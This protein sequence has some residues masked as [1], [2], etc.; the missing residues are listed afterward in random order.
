MKTDLDFSI[1]PHSAWRQVIMAGLALTAKVIEQVETSG[2]YQAARNLR[3]Q[4][5]PLD[6][7]LALIA[8]RL[9]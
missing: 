7:A 5:Y 2:H 6:L 3:K 8:G 1:T 9:P 4:G